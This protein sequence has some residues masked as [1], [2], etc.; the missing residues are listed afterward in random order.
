MLNPFV[1]DEVADGSVVWYPTGMKSTEFQSQVESSNLTDELWYNE[2]VCLD[3]N[4][5]RFHI[6]IFLYTSLISWY[7]FFPTIN[8]YKISIWNIFIT[9]ICFINLV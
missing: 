2:I 3:D 4:I 8:S 9:L 1:Y 6:S 5:F 7:K